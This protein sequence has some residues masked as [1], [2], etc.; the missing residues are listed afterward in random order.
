MG[1]GG[2]GGS[3]LERPPRFCSEV[4][5]VYGCGGSVGS[6]CDT[7]EDHHALWERR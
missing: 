5:A 7:A 3:Y 2:V 4:G 1:G 6:A